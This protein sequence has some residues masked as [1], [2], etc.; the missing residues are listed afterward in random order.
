[1]IWTGLAWNYASLLGARMT[2]GAWDPCDN[3]TRSRC[4]PTTTHGAALEGDERLPG[5]PAVRHLPHPRS[6]RRWRSRGVG[7]RRSTSSAIPAFI[8]AI[9]A[10]RLPE[11]VRGQQDRIQR[12]STR[13]RSRIEARHDVGQGGATASCSATARSPCWRWRRAVG[14]LF[15]G[16]IGTWSPIVL[17]ALP[18]HDDLAGGSRVQPARTR[19]VGRRAPVR[20]GGRLHD[21]P[22]LRCR[23]G[24]GRRRRPA[25]GVAAVRAHVRRQ[26]TRRSCSS[27]SRS[28]RCAWSRPRRR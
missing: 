8:V 1:M 4:S 10:R 2:L 28:R 27:A 9:L 22:W 6:R 14:S 12:G 16:S 7:G 11:P 26:P 21:V 25:A 5:G 24:P 20:L 15:F 19:R 3:P 13:R 18:R 23:P 17:R